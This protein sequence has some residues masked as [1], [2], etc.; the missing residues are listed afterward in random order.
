MPKKEQIEEGKADD[1]MLGSKVLLYVRWFQVRGSQR[2][3][4]D[5]W[6]NQQTYPVDKM[7][8]EH[9]PGWHALWVEGMPS[10]MSSTKVLL[11][12]KYSRYLCTVRAACTAHTIPRQKAMS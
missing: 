10:S 5:R 4:L 12:P 7:D 8:Q 1:D 11:L 3:L 2:R 9:G 6:L